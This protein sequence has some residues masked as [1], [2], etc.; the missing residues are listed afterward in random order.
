[1]TSGLTRTDNKE[2]YTNNKVRKRRGD[3]DLKVYNLEQYNRVS[4][5][6]KTQKTTNKVRRNK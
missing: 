6:L 1:M 5:D 4:T 3:L 2:V